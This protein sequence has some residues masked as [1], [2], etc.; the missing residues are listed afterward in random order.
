M[1]LAVLASC[2]KDNKVGGVTSQFSP[3]TTNVQGA[4][5]LGQKIETY[6]TS[7]GTGQVY[8]YGQTQTWANLAN[9]GLNL[10][11]RY[12]KST[13]NVASTGSNCDKKWGIFY[14][15]SYSSNTS[16]TY[17]SSA[18]SRKV[19][20][21]TVDITAKANELKGIINRSNPLIGIQ[22]SGYS[23]LIQTTDGTQYVIDTRYPLQANPIGIRTS[24]YTEYLYNITEN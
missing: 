2:G 9:T 4:A 3:I 13:G 6:G 17:T 7:F 10:G 21:N 20:N 16:P 14:V 5:D 19:N 8:Y 22:S 24:T 18:E 23:Y 1:V 11:Y 12:T 15:C